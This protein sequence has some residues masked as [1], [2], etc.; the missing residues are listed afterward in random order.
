MYCIISNPK[1]CIV[2]LTFRHSHP[3]KSKP[4][5]PSPLDKLGEGESQLIGYIM[6]TYEKLEIFKRL[7]V[8]ALALTLFILLH[9]QIQ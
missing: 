6:N 9:V 2:M 5:S 1:K 3:L 4:G 7:L 8:L